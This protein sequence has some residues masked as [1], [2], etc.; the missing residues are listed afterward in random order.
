[1]LDL[2]PEIELQIIELATIH[3]E[4]IHLTDM[5][6]TYDDNAAIWTSTQ[7]SLLFPPSSRSRLLLTAP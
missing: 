6:S 4:P 3:N 7:S 2:P 5:L 1:M